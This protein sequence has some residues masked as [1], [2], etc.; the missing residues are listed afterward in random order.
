MQTCHRLTVA[1]ALATYPVK[2]TTMTDDSISDGSSERERLLTTALVT[3]PVK[4]TTMTDD[5]ISDGRSER[6]DDD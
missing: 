5:S 4:E 6:D 1:T 2:E 3:D